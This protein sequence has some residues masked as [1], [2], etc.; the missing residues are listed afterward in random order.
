MDEETTETKWIKLE[1]KPRNIAIGVF[2][3]PQEKI[4]LEEANL[5]YQ[6]LE[7]QITSLKES[8][9]LILGGDFN[10]KLE[11]NTKEAKQK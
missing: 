8:N 1:C 3:G 5:I 9:K 10:A 6:S 2:Y 7:N 11:V 4:K